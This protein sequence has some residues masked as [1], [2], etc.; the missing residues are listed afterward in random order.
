MQQSIN[1]QAMEKL[2]NAE[3]YL[4]EMY[5]GIKDDIYATLPDREAAE[6]LRTLRRLVYLT[7]RES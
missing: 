3:Y 4:V 5:P 6:I 7:R 1:E 2:C